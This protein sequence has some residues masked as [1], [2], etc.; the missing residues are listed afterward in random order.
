[1]KTRRF[2]ILSSII[3]GLFAVASTFAQ[4]QSFT[5]ANVDYGFELPEGKWKMTVKPS[6]ASPNVEY[7]YGDRNDGHL[8]VRR[9]KVSKDALITD[10][11]RD[12]EQKLQFL[13]GY[14][15]GPDEKFAG[16]LRGA[17][18][19]F[20]FVRAGKPMSGRFYFLRADDNTVYVLRFTGFRDSLRSI[21]NQ[22]DSIGRTFSI[23]AG[24]S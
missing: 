19:N 2:S 6:A 11:V 21:R 14:V 16:R 20:E 4:G 10:I 22:T 1:M 17:I 12:E 24:K 3:I 9:L 5:D 7:V 23:G 13:P 15:A 18:F 8:E